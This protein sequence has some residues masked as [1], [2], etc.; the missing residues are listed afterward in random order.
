MEVKSSKDN[1]GTVRDG[2]SGSM[3]SGSRKRGE[4]KCTKFCSVIIIT[5][6]GIVLYS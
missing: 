1:T 4:I 5:A 6:V 2:V 3:K